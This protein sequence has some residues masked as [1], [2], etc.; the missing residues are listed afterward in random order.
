[1]NPNQSVV[2]ELEG[3]AAT[4]LR[5]AMREPAPAVT[6]ARLGDLLHHSHNM[7]TGPFPKESYQWHR[8]VPRA[9]SALADRVTLAVP[10]GRSHV[11]LRV[12]QKNGQM[13]WTSPVFLNYR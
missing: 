9:A 6:A 12:K 4:V 8:L 1:E 7:Q 2:L 11:Y 5:L 10:K 3:D 13:A